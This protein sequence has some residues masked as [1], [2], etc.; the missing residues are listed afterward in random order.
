MK[1]YISQLK[2]KAA[3]Y[4]RKTYGVNSFARTRQPEPLDA[5]IKRWWVNLPD[6][7]RYRQFSI[8]EV[9]SVCNGKF[10]EKPALREVAFSLRALGW[11]QIREWKKPSNN[12]RMWCPPE[13]S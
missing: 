2:T 3:E 7:S 8:T 1:T 4:Q 12:R 10:R 5:Q 9:A 13:K 11:I 6:G